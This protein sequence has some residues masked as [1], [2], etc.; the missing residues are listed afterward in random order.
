[1]RSLTA[2]NANAVSCGRVPV[3]MT[4]YA[5]CC[6]SGSIPPAAA[7][8]TQRVLALHVES[9]SRG[10]YVSR[11]IARREMAGFRPGFGPYD[12]LTH[13]VALGPGRG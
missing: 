4:V 2:N 12:Q 13:F 10:S 3:G 7:Y 8:S 1:M 11:A 6:V 5:M 9:R